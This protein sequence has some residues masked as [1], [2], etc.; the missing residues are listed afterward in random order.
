MCMRADGTIESVAVVDVRENVAGA[1]LN[2][3][4]SQGAAAAV[5]STYAA[6]MAAAAATKAKAG[7]R[8]GGG[9]SG[10]GRGGRRRKS[11]DSRGSGPRRHRADGFGS[12]LPNLR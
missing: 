2:D 4:G 6:T 3:A 5:F 8:D 1:V 9:A 7:T 10:G 12:G 11:R